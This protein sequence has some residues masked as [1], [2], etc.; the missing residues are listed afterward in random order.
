MVEGAW[1]TFRIKRPDINDKAGER[2]VKELEAKL[3]ERENL[4]AELAQENL[5]LKK[6]RDGRK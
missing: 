5:E 6:E 3:L 1:E 4:I 2:R